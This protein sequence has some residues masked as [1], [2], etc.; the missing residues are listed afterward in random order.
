MA[1][2]LLS[3]ASGLLLTPSAV[4]TPSNIMMTATLEPK[5]AAG[6]TGS[7]TVE[8]TVM[9]FGGSSVRDAERITEVCNIITS[10]IELGEKPHAV[11]DGCHT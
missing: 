2:S 4:R 6:A 5:A 7:S 9:K 3:V 8:K 10:R 11:C 1:L